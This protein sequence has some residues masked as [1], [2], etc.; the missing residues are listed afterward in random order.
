MYVASM[1]DYYIILYSQVGFYDQK[2]EMHF[3]QRQAVTLMVTYIWGTEHD[4][5]NIAPIS[6]LTFS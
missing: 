4:E 1:N 5:L 2:P 6:A 3:D